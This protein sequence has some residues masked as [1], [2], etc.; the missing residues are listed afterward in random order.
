MAHKS[1]KGRKNLQNTR[2][3]VKKKNNKDK[4]GKPQGRI[5]K[6]ERKRLENEASAAKDGGKAP[7]VSKEKKARRLSAIEQQHRDL[8]HANEKILLVG[9]GN[10]SFTRS[11]CKAFG[12]GNCSNVYATAFDNEAAL[13]HKYPD[14]EK[15]I[16]E[17]E[18]AG[19]TTLTGVDATRL[20]KVEEF[21]GAFK[22]IVFYFPHLGGGE[23]DVE[24]SV[25]QHRKLLAAFFSS[26]AQC[27]VQERGAA[28]HVA[29]KSGEPYKSW[30]IGQTARMATEELDLVTAVPFAM[31]AWEGYAHRRTMGFE[32]KFSK[33]D[34]E[35]LKNG[36]KVYVFS[37]RRQKGAAA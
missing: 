29:L 21:K 7:E 5:S 3:L 6:K 22:K 33:A 9:E 25:A 2:S 20:H 37:R 19:A 30:K 17:I 12:D 4:K 31:S 23:S 26:A 27:L 16:A 8:Y 28:I 36:A 32:P 10:F 34:N 14:V 18:A 24:K 1:L 13:K 11:L 35:E 15:L